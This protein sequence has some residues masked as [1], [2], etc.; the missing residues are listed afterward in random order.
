MKVFYCSTCFECYYIHPQELATVCGCIALFRCV[1]VYWCGS[2]GVEQYTHI[3]SPTPE[4][5][6][7]N[8]RNM[9]SNKNS[10]KL[11]SSLFNLFN[12]YKMFFCTEM[13][14]ELEWVIEPKDLP[15]SL[16]LLGRIHVD[17]LGV[18]SQR[19]S[20]EMLS[21]CTST[22]MDILWHVNELPCPTVRRACIAVVG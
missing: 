9:L 18:H 11:T 14:K 13:W 6:C 1:L 12:Y 20:R 7:N 15:S 3:Q 19:Y 5:E 10:H 4:D 16:C 22:S 17:S 8:I 2:A 21:Y